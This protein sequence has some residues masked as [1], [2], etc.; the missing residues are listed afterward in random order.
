[1]ALRLLRYENN[2]MD[3]DNDHADLVMQLT[4]QIRPLLARRGPDVTSAV[5]ANLTALWL[6]GHMSTD[7]K[8]L[9]R[10]RAELLADHVAL[11]KKLVAPSEAELV[12]R[13]VD[14]SD[15]Q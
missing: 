1:L 7:R 6:A 15:P 4:E 10:Y 9:R 11:V 8:A 14:R 3:Q 5:L 12:D 13:M 2:I